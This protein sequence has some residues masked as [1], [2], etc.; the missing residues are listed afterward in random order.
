MNNIIQSIVNSKHLAVVGVSDNKFGGAI[1]KTLKKRGYSVY[2]VHPSHKFF[3]NDKCYANLDQLPEN[4]ESAIFAVSPNVSEQII[5]QMKNST[6]TQ[7]WF[8]QGN[9]Y[10]IAEEKAQLRGIQTVS[11]K[12]ILMYAEPVGG[13]HALHRFFSKLTRNY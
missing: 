6:I 9:L 11:G 12:C 3:D 7:I 13:I 2:P 1:Y 4:I 10:T 8:Q 5:E